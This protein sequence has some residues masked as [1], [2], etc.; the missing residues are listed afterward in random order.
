M[1]ICSVCG[2]KNEDFAVTCSSCKGYVQS[3][4]DTLDLFR[5]AW[6]LI[7]SP[8]IAF[9]RIILSRHKNYALLLS[10][11]FGVS[12]VYSVFWYLSWGVKF[13]NILTLVGTGFA[14]GPVVGILFSLI[15]SLALL[16]SARMFGGRTTLKNMF[17]VL[18][19][20]YVPVIFSLAVVFPIEIAVFGLDFFG[21]NPSPMI[22]NPIVYIALLAFDALA[23]LCSY[24]LL[25][26]GISVLKGC[27]LWKAIVTT[28]PPMALLACGALGLRMPS[29]TLR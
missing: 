24:A 27:A 26:E 10:S 19:Y 28:L 1:I 18:S 20:A 23:T 15:L 4:I 22:I 29:W 16:S 2:S 13:S 21:S 9:K 8:R 25:V 11:T 5:T 6:G 12:L 7:E 14:V 3:K 17:A